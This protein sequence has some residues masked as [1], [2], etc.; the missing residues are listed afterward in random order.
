MESGNVVE[1]IDQKQIICAV[2]L[3][4]KKQRLRVLT[5]SNRE[6]NLAA[7]RICHKS[8]IF[9]DIAQS[10]DNLIQKLN[11]LKNERLSLRKKI[12]VS[13]LWEILNT[14]QE[15]IDVATMAQ[16]AFSDEITHNHISAVIRA[17]FE[18]KIYFK[19][20]P[21]RFFPNNVEQVEQQKSRIQEEIRREELINDGS[22]WIKKILKE[23]NPEIPSDKTSIIEILKSAYLFQKQS[24]DYSLARSIANKAGINLENDILHIL[25]KLGLWDI[26]ENLDIQRFETP[27]EFSEK[28]IDTAKGINKNPSIIESFSIY[29]DFTSLPVIT[30]DGQYTLD[31]DDAIS[32]ESFED[33]YRVGIHIA[34]VSA[35]IKKNSLLD[36]E[37]LNRAISIYMPDKKIPMLPPV[38]AE[39]LCSLKENMVRPSISLLIKL[40]KDAE[41]I[42]YDIVP[43]LIRVE[44]QLTYHDA[45]TIVEED[46][47]LKALYELAKKIHNK[48]LE[49]DAIQINLPEIHI[50]IEEN[51]EISIN[52][53]CR[54]NPCRLLVAEMMILAN[55]LMASYLKKHN[56]P[57]IFRSQPG[58]KER[59]I[60]NGQGSLFENWMQRRHLARFVLSSQP[61]IHAGLGLDCYLTATSP[62]R[63]Y[64]DLISQRQLKSIMNLEKPY[65]VEEIDFFIQTVQETVSRAT[66]IQMARNRYW[67]IKY[68]EKRIGELED[69]IVLDK[70]WNYY[71]VL[72][73][74]YMM[75]APLPISPGLSLKVQNVIKV[76][77]SKANA[78][79]NIIHVSL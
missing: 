51:N 68:L 21:D 5:E 15:W 13:E 63:K 76:K 53:V 30:I 73:T 52:K 6:V 10:R 79:D 31:H 59:I 66:R 50:F 61:E 29:Q 69:A 57:S 17:F 22:K 48:R 41:V 72:L 37:A 3:E 44:R 55:W 28:L 49:N 74:D 27:I 8:E 58:P 12:N 38:L 75:E 36:K 64:F 43:A 26:N 67:I 24:N 39:N 18:N 2:V 42:D 45:N 46:I 14:E 60:K 71:N 35:Y 78:R 47:E 7:K 1:Y 19:F 33:S 65:S 34:D 9:L 20:E 56:I 25:I 4:I 16:F 40:T 23:K 54:E 70:R 77:I 62:I 11:E 32:I